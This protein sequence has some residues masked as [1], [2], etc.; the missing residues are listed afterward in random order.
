[1]PTQIGIIGAGGML[2]YH[3]AGFRAAG[4]EI[5]AIADL[6][7]A[8]AKAAADKWGIPAA[9]GSPEAMLAAC[10]GIE[11]VAVIVPN[12]FHAPLAIQMLEAGKHVFCEKPPALNAGEVGQ[13]IAAADKAG[14]RLMFNFNNRARPES[15]ALRGYIGDGTVGRINSAQAKWVR[16]TGIPGFGGWFTQR[17]LSGGGPLIDLLHM[18][19]LALYFMDFPEPAVVLARTFDDFINDKGFKGPWGIP[20]REG[21]VNDVEAAAHGMVTF[22]TGQVLTLQVSWA[23]MVKREEVSVTFQGTQAGGK[24]ERLFGSDGIDAT[25]I[26]T[27]ELYVQEHG[28]AVNRSIVTSACEDMGRI[29]SAQ[30]FVLAIEGKEEPINTPDQALKLMK[31]IDAVYA[32]AASGKAVEL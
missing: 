31:I 14:K 24:I 20:D 12:K 13:M 23:E 27:C 26:D 25:A 18:I 16:R 17:A 29:R 7:E 6:N 22:K 10:P 32:S 8:A 5:V 2:Q 9:Y 15:F 28:N 19:D 21:V 1:M 3:A 30:N 11:G 4:A